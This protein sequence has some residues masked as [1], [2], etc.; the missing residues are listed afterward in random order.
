MAGEARALIDE[1]KTVAVL[2]F[3][4]DLSRLAD[5]PVC[6]VQLGS[7]RA[8]TDVAAR[9]YAALRECDDLGADAVLARILTTEHALSPAI[10]DRLRR[11]AS[12]IVDLR[13]ADL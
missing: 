4:E 8:P 1:G 9:L 10:R 12:R 5:V 13:G 7:E 11:A 2:V 3:A 6:L